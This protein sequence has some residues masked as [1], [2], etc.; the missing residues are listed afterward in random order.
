MKKLDDIPKEHPFSVPDDYFDKLPGRI[1]QRVQHPERTGIFASQGFTRYALG[2]FAVAAVASVWLW[3]GTGTPVT[4]S[5]EAIL[6]SLETV[7]LVT[8]LEEEDITT[9]ELLDDVHF[10]IEDADEIEAAVFNLELSDADLN[11]WID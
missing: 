8:Y 10:N 9:D 7:D 11:A 5:P 1:Q 6:S 4:Q 3:T 2:L